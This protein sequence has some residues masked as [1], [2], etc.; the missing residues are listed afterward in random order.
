M[1]EPPRDIE[2][3][4]AGFT[5]IE[6]L[7][8]IGIISILAAMLL[9]GLARAR[10]SARRISCVN[11]LK[12]VAISLKI[13]TS[14]AKGGYPPL[15]DLMGDDCNVK[16]RNVLMFNG[17]AMF[18]DYLPDA[19]VLICPSDAD[20]P[21]SYE[22]GIW[23]RRDGVDG[24]PI[25]GSTNPCLIDDTSYFYFP[26]IIRRD[27][28]VDPA[29]ADLSPAFYNGL[30]EALARDENSAQWAFEDELGEQHQVLRL[31]E[32]IERFMIEDINNPSESHMA[33]S[34][35]PIMFDRISLL[36]TDFN[37]IPGGA[38]VLFM[39]GHAEYVRYPSREFYPVSR[40]WADLAFR[41]KN[42]P[43]TT[44]PQP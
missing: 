42:T 15:Q 5:L 44:G 1:H 17:K 43:Q 29:T 6:L 16:N 2:H 26:W 39:D 35:I 23:N 40:A 4:R 3:P 31:R 10:E 21:D 36:A 38:N 25:G 22:A 28:I 32:G 41:L 27:W 30:Q 9:P 34:D 18:P 37:H 19:E 24:T 7:V 8:V 13:Y 11:N 12:Q 20:G 33:Q 14:E